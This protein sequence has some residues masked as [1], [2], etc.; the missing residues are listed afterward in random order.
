M[1]DYSKPEPLWLRVVTVIAVGAE[2]AMIFW[3]V[4]AKAVPIVP[5]VPSQQVCQYLADYALVARALAQDGSISELQADTALDRI[6]VLRDPMID[7]MQR[8][9][10]EHARVETLRNA[11]RYAAEFLDTCISLQGRIEPFFGVRL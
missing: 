11:Q 1:T 8:L 7:E 2:L 9:L 5:R 6:Y 4:D 3:V 10:R